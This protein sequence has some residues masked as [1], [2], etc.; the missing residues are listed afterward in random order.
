MLHKLSDGLQKQISKATLLKNKPLLITDAD[1]VLLNFVKC[2][3][4]YLEKKGPIGPLDILVALNLN[5]D[6]CHHHQKH[7]HSIGLQR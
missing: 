4:I 1:E 7:P 2:F 5:L 6:H 3:E